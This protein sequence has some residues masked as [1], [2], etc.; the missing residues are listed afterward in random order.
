MKVD[1]CIILSAGF[2]TR[3][4]S[5]GQ[6]IP[7]PIWPVF[8]KS[9]LEL[10]VDYARMLGAENIYVNLHFN[11]NQILQHFHDKPDYED[12]NFLYEEEI[13]D[14][15]GAIHNL[16]SQEEVNY[17][18]NLLILN[19]DQFLFYDWD[20]LKEASKLIDNYKAVMM[21]VKVDPRF[22]HGQTLLDDNGILKKIIPN[23]EITQ[24]DFIYTYSGL[25]LL[26]LENLKPQ[27]GPSSLY[28]SVITYKT[29]DIKMVTVDDY[30]Y[31]D[32]GT[33]DRYW[34]S[35]FKALKDLS[36]EETYMFTK[37]LIDN[38]AINT[39]KYNP[40]TESYN[41]DNGAINLTQEAPSLKDGQI[42]IKS[43]KP[44]KECNGKGVICG[45]L[46]EPVT[47][48]DLDL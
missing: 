15:G 36:S 28:E 23:K 16:A 42:A 35:M 5:I 27:E 32:F 6:I 17:K 10:Q 2:G 39:L 44:V 13:L 4:K 14:I 21:A 7:K 43:E 47:F 40:D 8:E 20:K 41:S 45:S 29:D 25:S 3:M 26:K 18:G 12:I 24:K 33:I 9:I 34:T 31:W 19:G 37:F 1:H 22:G 11:H 46:F 30:E 38:S 48:S